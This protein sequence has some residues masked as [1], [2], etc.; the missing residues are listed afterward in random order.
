MVLCSRWRRSNILTEPSAPTEANMSLPP[1]AR[2]NAM[3]YT[4]STPKQ[5]KYS[6]GLVSTLPPNSQLN[7]FPI[8]TA[9][10]VTTTVTAFC[11][12]LEFPGKFFSY[13]PKGR[14][15]TSHVFTGLFTETE[16]I[17]FLDSDFMSKWKNPVRCLLPLIR[18]WLQLQFDVLPHFSEIFCSIIV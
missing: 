16:H 2:L 3:S 6:P 13:L 8:Q 7:G 4:C 9:E 11:L 5:N 18:N 15:R 17:Y 1:P 12:I 14:E 10:I